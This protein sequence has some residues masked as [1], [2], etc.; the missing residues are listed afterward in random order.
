MLNL[1]SPLFSVNSLSSS[2]GT[3]LFVLY[4]AM[5]GLRHLMEAIYLGTDK[6]EISTSKESGKFFEYSLHNVNGGGS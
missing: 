3:V 6:R 5:H 4:Y 1:F 2:E